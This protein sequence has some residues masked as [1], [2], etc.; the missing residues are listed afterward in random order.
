[1][2]QDKTD[3]E[4]KQLES[5]IHKMVR[6]FLKNDVPAIKHKSRNLP[7]LQWSQENR[8]EETVESL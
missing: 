5:R 7:L 2:N 4:W 6:Q 8:N 1:M 3:H